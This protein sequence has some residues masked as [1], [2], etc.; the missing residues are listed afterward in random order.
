[1]DGILFVVGPCGNEILR[2]LPITSS[3][4]LK[5]KYIVNIIDRLSYEQK[6]KLLIYNNVD[7]VHLSS[8]SS[9][10][11]RASPIAIDSSGDDAS[12]LFMFSVLVI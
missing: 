9:R 10:I 11:M 8:Y 1:M 3:A 5:E 7:G 6:W 4:R 12:F 2:Y